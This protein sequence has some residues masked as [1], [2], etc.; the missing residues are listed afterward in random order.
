[1]LL[2]LVIAASFTSC[3]QQ[4]DNNE[5]SAANREAN[6]QRNPDFLKE[7]YPQL[8]KLLAN[9]PDLGKQFNDFAFDVANADKMITSE[10]QL[11]AVFT[12]R[13]TLLTH[14]AN[15]VIAPFSNDNYDWVMTH[16]G[17]KLT[18]EIASL[19]YHVATAEGMYAYIG[20][21]PILE[22]QVA[23]YAPEPFKLFLAFNDAK[24]QA[25]QSEYP[26]L[27]LTG[28]KKMVATGEQLLTKYPDSPYAQ[29]IAEDFAEALNQLTDIHALPGQFD[30][31]F[32]NGGLSTDFYPFATDI[33]QIR[34][35]SKEYPQSKYAKILD[36]IGQ[37]FS[38]MVVKDDF[39]QPVYAV[40][41]QTLKTDNSNPQQS[42][43]TSCMPQAQKIKRIFL[44]RGIDMAHAILYYQGEEE[45]CAIAYRF[46]TDNKKAQKALQDL[47][48]LD[49]KITATIQK[50][51]FNKT[52]YI[53]EEL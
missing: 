44:D 40:I 10:A 3:N 18:K 14:L 42:N 34:D 12:L 2:L 20:T 50:L 36:R 35:F 37:N 9:K 51:G 8:F 26:F 25:W 28:E 1:M 43:F 38:E 4:V 31:S 32:L 24:A 23:Q 30:V 48:A 6:I 52:R 19:G 47:Q 7:N 15:E 21:A 16:D 22:N 17:E 27:D 11:T 53:W 45:V 46:F 41:V 33:V 5:S 39:A 49:P 13:D 29:Q